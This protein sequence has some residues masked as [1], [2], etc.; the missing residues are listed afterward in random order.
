MKYTTQHLNLHEL[1]SPNSFLSCLCNYL[2]ITKT[3]I[4]K[5]ILREILHCILSHYIVRNE[6][7]VATTHVNDR[8]KYSKLALAGTKWLNQ[9]LRKKVHLHSHFAS[10]VSQLTALLSALHYLIK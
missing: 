8:L 4:S 3:V 9:I 5:H 10:S 2:C 7:D 1:F 6:T